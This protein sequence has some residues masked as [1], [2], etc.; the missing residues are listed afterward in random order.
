MNNPP[1]FGLPANDDDRS[2]AQAE[3]SEKLKQA[4]SDLNAQM[5]AMV[6]IAAERHRA[7]RFGEAEQLYR[8]VLEARPADAE[9]VHL[10]GVLLLQKGGGDDAAEGLVLLDRAASMAPE[11]PDILCNLASALRGAGRPAEAGAI[12]QKAL[13]A[14]PGLTK[15]LYGLGAARMD[16]GDLRGARTA[17]EAAAGAEPDNPQI[18]RC[19]NSVLR[20]LGAPLGPEC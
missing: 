12:F 20:A 18:R 10:L 17:L 5:T 8:A 9:T 6:R 15:A 7:G 14:A 4:L 1:V 3:V 19:L 13:F 16:T 11:N 2:A